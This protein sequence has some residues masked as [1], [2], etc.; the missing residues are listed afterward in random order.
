MRARLRIRRGELREAI[1]TSKVPADEFMGAL[2][3]FKP[4]MKVIADGGGDAAKSIGQVGAMLAQMTQNG[5]SADQASQNLRNA[6]LHLIDANGPQRDMLGQLFAQTGSKMT[7]DDL[8]KQLSDPNIGP[9]GVMKQ[10]SDVVAESAR[11]HRACG[12]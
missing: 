9:L 11:R 1:G 5:T 8:S 3:N 7:P 2:H 4:I 10:I 6:L 12:D